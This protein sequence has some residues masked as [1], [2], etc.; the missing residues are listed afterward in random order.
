MKTIKSEFKRRTVVS[1]IFDRRQHENRMLDF[2]ISNTT[3]ILKLT[4]HEFEF[5]G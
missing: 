4:L 2:T 1:I 3:I 5:F